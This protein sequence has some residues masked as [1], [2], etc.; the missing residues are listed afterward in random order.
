MKTKSYD[1]ALNEFRNVL[2]RSSS[3]TDVKEIIEDRDVVLT[4]YGQ[5]F[6]LE[7]VSILKEDDFRSFLYFENNRHWTSLYRHVNAL[8]ADMNDLRN[9]L[10]ILLNPTDSLA[11]RFDDALNQIKGL[12][13]GLA[14]AILLVSSPKDYG[15]WN[16]TSEGALRELG[17]W[18][19]YVRGR[20]HGQKYENLNALLLSLSDDLDID[21]WTLDALMWGVLGEKEESKEHKTYETAKPEKRVV[22]ESYSFFDSV[23][24]PILKTRLSRLASAPLDTIIREAGVIFESTLRAAGN[25]SSNQFGV[26]MVDE[27][28][29]PGGKLVFSSHGGEQQGIQYL[30]RGAM[31]FIRNPPMHKIIDYPESVAKQYIRLIDSL[32]LLL[33]QATHVEEVTVDDIRKMLQRAK[34]SQNHRELFRVIYQSGETGIVFSRLTKAMKMTSQ[35]LSGVLGSLGRRI[36][37]TNRLKDKGGILIV[38]D[39]FETKDDEWLY[40]MRPVLR[41]ALEAEKLV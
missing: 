41:K 1:H 29:E 33:D 13:K 5:I 7:N 34:I 21:L 15:V 36:N 9:T 8:T 30:F 32:L 28:L 16:N 35:Q 10:E 14:S 18:R 20:T 22:K 6:S 26:K 17:L 25:I 12:G 2:N 23:E 11:N 37:Q 31:Q 4:R 38:F 3:I 19:E 40:I 39:I 27:L 24:H